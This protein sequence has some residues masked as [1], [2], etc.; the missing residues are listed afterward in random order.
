[1][2]GGVRLP[3]WFEGVLGYI[4][5]AKGLPTKFGACTR[6]RLAVKAGEVRRQNW[7]LILHSGAMLLGLVGICKA[8]D[9]CVGPQ[10]QVPCAPINLCGAGILRCAEPEGRVVGKF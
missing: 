1:M 9:P 7:S 5:I 2:E 4:K 8:C 3:N 6:A 10:Q